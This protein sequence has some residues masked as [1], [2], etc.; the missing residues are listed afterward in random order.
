[1]LRRQQP[2]EPTELEGQLDDVLAALDRG[3]HLNPNA[4]Q[5][6]SSDLLLVHRTTRRP[7]SGKSV[8]IYNFLCMHC[9]FICNPDVL[10]LC[11]HFLFTAVELNMTFYDLKLTIYYFSCLSQY[12]LK[13]KMV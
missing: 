12:S 5:Q 10:D 13:L 3:D 1:M 4:L 11:R 7:I 8:N 9:L 2:E 6:A